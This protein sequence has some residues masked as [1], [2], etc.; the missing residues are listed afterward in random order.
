MR[1]LRTIAR[2][3]HGARRSPLVQLTAVGT[4]ALSLTL[5]GAVELAAHNVARLAA[6]WNAG[7]QMTVYLDDGVRGDRAQQI[8]QALAKLPGIESV[9]T[10]DAHE[11]W[12]RLQRSLGGRA[13]LLDGVEEGFLPASI[14]ATLKP[15]VS[16]VIR[17]H[18]AFER[19]KHA[20]G[21]EDVELT[22][23]WAAKLR[24]VEHLLRQAGLAVGL[25]VVI[26]CLYVVGSTIRL[27]VFA[28]KDEI[29]ILKLV[30]ATNAYVKG[31]FLVEGL[32]QG[33]LGTSLAVALL[34]G[35]FRLAQPRVTAAL[36]D[37]L[38]SAPLGF[39][40]P[41]ELAIALGAGALLG[42]GGSALALGRYVRT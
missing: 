22:G 2:G 20:A 17:A 7:V 24:A 30:G 26:A 21:V 42:L 8:A 25:L 6:G 14:E 40:R 19:L 36:G 16:E 23:D 32:L 28:R 13:S 39:F 4:I 1:L 37:L 29:E 35:V 11:A 33:M 10:V 3:L 31:P 41:A 38:A 15:G 34:Y 12:Q 9:R 27:G 18:P 5:V